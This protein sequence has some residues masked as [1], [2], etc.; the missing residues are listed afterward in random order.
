MAMSPEELKKS[1]DKVKLTLLTRRNTTFI[2]TILFSLKLSWNNEDTES[3]RTNGLE[4]Q[5]NTEFW[6]KLNVEQRISLLVHEAWHVALNHVVNIQKFPVNPQRYSKAADFVIN[7][8]LTETGF[9]KIPGGLYDSTYKN[10]STMEVY[11]TLPVEI[12]LPQNT[13]EDLLKDILP[14]PGDNQNQDQDPNNKN[15]TNNPPQTEQQKQQALA[16]LENKI[17]QMLTKANTMAQINGEKLAG[18]VPGDVLLHIDSLLNPKLHWATILRNFMSAFMKNDYSFRKPNRRFL[19]DFY[20]PSLYSEGL[21]EI[22]IAIDTSGSVSDE[23]FAAFITEIEDIR[24]KLTPK[25]TTIIDFDTTIKHVHK[26]NADEDIS[27]L[28]FSGR[29][30]TSLKCVFD[31]YGKNKPEVLIVFSDLCCKVIKEDPGYPVI[32]VCVNNPQ[33]E[34]KFGTLIHYDTSDL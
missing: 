30:G 32:W 18:N 15:N 34:V 19:P 13:N 29:G 25:L 9:A 12:K 2:S 1:L 6:E 16:N 24:Q 20:L 28:P 8:L 11:D 33:A 22:G 17:D 21:N 14:N 4:I 27:N 23:E 3:A 5:L 31:Y 10:K 7:S 26:I